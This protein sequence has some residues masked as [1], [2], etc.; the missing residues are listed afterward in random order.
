MERGR[1]DR[2]RG[3]VEL[4][5]RGIRRVACARRVMFA[6]VYEGRC[7]ALGTT[8]V[9]EKQHIRVLILSSHLDG[10]N[11]VDHDHNTSRVVLF[12]SRRKE[13]IERPDESEQRDILWTY[14]RTQSGMRYET[15]VLLHES[16]CGR[17][18]L[19]AC[20][21]IDMHFGRSSGREQN[22]GAIVYSQS[23]CGRFQSSN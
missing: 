14:N 1:G 5:H 17:T 9:P 23:F 4:R 13:P 18:G 10:K 3:K 2:G 8:N 6:G 15:A 11:T 19:E 12:R 16:E 7:C 20:F 21:M 22:G